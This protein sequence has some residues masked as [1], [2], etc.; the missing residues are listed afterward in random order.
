[1]SG[2]PL[3]VDLFCGLG[4]WSKGFLSEGYRA[5]GFDIER[6]R[7]PRPVAESG[8]IKRPGLDWSDRSKR[9]SVDAQF[10]R[11]PEIDPYADWNQY[12]GELVLQDILTVHGSQFR[13]AAC[14]VASPPCQR[15][16]WMAM[17]WSESKR[18][19][20]WQRWLRDSQW[21][22]G[23]TLNDLFDACFRI[24]DEASAAAGHH[25]P[26][27][28]ENVKGAQPWVGRAKAHY[29]SYYLWGDVEDGRSKNR[30]ASEVKGNGRTWFGESH[31]E[32]FEGQPGNPARGEG[33][34]CVPTIQHGCRASEDAAS[35]IVESTDSM[36]TTANVLQLKSGNVTHTS[37][38]DPQGVKQAGL[39]GHAW[40][41]QGAASMSS[42]SSARKAA[43][44]AIA[45]IPFELAQ[46]VARAFKP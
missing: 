44:A 11:P 42:K 16:S 4:G 21:S 46:Y 1:V 30:G 19:I 12:P 23:F 45:E 3:V 24:R 40:F 6:H 25:I 10:N 41:D 27:V 39:S 2:R 8:A 17:P 14:I 36:P 29:G 32:K 37:L 7:Y 34:K 13:D 31:G 33:M 28:V 35:S 18:E 5:V 15:Y 26:L 9:G 43:S 22:P 20:R 38:A